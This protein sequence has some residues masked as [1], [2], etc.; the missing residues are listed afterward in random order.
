MT[1][2]QFLHSDATVNLFALFLGIEKHK[3][4]PTRTGTTYSLFSICTRS[5]VRGIV[6][7]SKVLL[8]TNFRIC[9]GCSLRMSLPALDKI[10]DS[11]YWNRECYLEV[12]EHHTEQADR[13]TE[14]ISFFKMEPRSAKESCSSF[15]LF[16]V[17]FGTIK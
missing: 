2:C 5:S 7:Y 12:N 3:I 16:L 4:M 1:S 15:K 13:T 17:M 9:Q 14:K 10:R 6:K 8:F 11:D